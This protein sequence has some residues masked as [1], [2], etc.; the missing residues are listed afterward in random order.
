MATPPEMTPVT[1]SNIQE[2]GHCGSALWV[3]FKNGGLY[4]YPSAGREHL[5]AM[6]KADS[7]G[8]YLHTLVKPHH[9]GERA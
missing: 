7:P 6:T 3:R 8:S 9:K 2:V 1:S 4:R 5:D